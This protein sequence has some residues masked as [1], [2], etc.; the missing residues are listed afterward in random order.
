[1][2]GCF[3]RRLPA[4][5]RCSTVRSTRN[6]T[7]PHISVLLRTP[8]LRFANPRCHPRFGPPGCPQ[9]FPG[10]GFPHP[11]S[12]SQSRPLHEGDAVAAV[13]HEAR[14]RRGG[15][16]V[17]RKPRPKEKERGVKERGKEG[18]RRTCLVVRLSC[19]SGG[20]RRP[21]A[22]LGISGCVLARGHDRNSPWRHLRDGIHDPH[23]RG[24]LPLCPITCVH[25][26]QRSNLWAAKTTA[27]GVARDLGRE[28]SRGIRTR[29]VH[30]R[31]VR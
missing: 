19:S 21:V 31:G 27:K 4:S 9:P 28:S 13:S 11:L 18:K 25:R 10:A 1:M 30:E 12:S 26:L 14:G 23:F 24:L 6:S 17:E 20:R 7:V 29:V 8:V 5:T 3:R 22:V 2:V 15:D 16:R